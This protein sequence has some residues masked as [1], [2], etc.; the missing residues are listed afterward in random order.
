[1][2]LLLVSF[3]HLTYKHTYINVNN[4]SYGIRT[5]S[6][7]TNYGGY[8]YRAENL[9][10]CQTKFNSSFNVRKKKKIKANPI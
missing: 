7:C 9:L 3:L 1:M 10:Q 8:K 5:E 6:I 2:Y 4:T